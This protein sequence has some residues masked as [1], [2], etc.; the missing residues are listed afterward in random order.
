MHVIAHIWDDNANL[1]SSAEAAMKGI[2]E[3]STE[4][5][6]VTEDIRAAVE[7]AMANPGE[8]AAVDDGMSFVRYLSISN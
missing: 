1:Y 6:E 8:A 3:G 7:W 4:D 2:A 5:G